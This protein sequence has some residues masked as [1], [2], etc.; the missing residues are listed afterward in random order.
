MKKEYFRWF[1]PSLGKDMELNVYGHAGKPV[2]VFPS[3]GGSYYE[4]E[5]LGMVGCIQ[6]FIDERR[7]MLFT[8]GSVDNESW[9]NTAVSPGERANRHNA[10]DAYIIQEVVPF[11]K[12][13]SGRGDILATGCSL[14]GY[15]AMN[16]TLRHPDVFNA[17]IALS[18][19][20][21]LSYFVGD[22]VDDNVYF[23]SPLL[24]LPNCHDSWFI[25]RYRQ[26]QI[27]ACCGRGAW[28]DEMQHDTAALDAIF[29]DKQIPA[30]CDFWG[31]DVN[32]DWNWWRVQ[33]PYFLGYI[34]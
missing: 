17:V 2:I 23:N 27:I 10:Y 32:H 21:Q 7:V 20:Y 5:D 12:S 16:F 22:Y 15:H 4:Y 25:D 19:C 11:V 1:S 18:G 30:W 24:Y 34:V 3:S 29:R 8:V 9:M 26:C 33:L 14:G 28:E 6:N 13:H 31:T